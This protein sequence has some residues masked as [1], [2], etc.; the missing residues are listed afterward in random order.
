MSLI[1]KFSIDQVNVTENG[2]VEIRQRQDIIDDSTNENIGSQYKR[3]TL[4]PGQDTTDQD[5]KVIAICNAAW[6]TD[7]IDAY[8][9][10]LLNKQKVD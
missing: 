8:K 4:Y 1:Q 10:Q 9:A 2:I 7:V 6:T 5:D 3:W